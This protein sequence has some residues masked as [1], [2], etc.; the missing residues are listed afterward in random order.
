M[1]LHRLHRLHPALHFKRVDNAFITI[2]QITLARKSSKSP[3]IAGRCLLICRLRE[4]L[5]LSST[6]TDVQEHSQ[7]LWQICPPCRWQARSQGEPHK[8]QTCLCHI[9]FTLPQSRVIYIY[10]FLYN[11]AFIQW[12]KKSFFFFPIFVFWLHSFRCLWQQ[13]Q[14][15]MGYHLSD[16]GRRSVCK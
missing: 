7:Y 8:A 5:L 10:L 4:M 14:T 6:G 2:V 1:C 11:P 12:F 16:P 9:N 13:G 3:R 15:K